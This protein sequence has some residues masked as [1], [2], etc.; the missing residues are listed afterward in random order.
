MVVSIDGAC[1]GNTTP[2]ARAS[3][4]VYFGPGSSH[5][6]YGLLENTLPQ[7]STRAEIESL[8]QALNIICKITDEDF[9]LTRIKIATDSSFL[10][11]AMGKWAEER[12]DDGDLGS[13]GTKIAYFDIL[14]QLH[15]KLDY[16]EY[17]D[18]GGRE[19]Q[20]W[21]VSPEQ[22]ANANALANQAFD[23]T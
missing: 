6:T 9:W 10:A 22:N 3:Y 19:V 21:H 23:E 7:T 12:T 13:D 8:L 14:K 1:R 11:N 17:G 4:G 5:N 18:D 16:M 15:D 2:T 20:F